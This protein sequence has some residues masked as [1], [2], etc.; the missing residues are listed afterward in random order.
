MRKNDANEKTYFRVKDR[1]FQI[2]DGWWFATREGDRGPFS[3]KSKAA[4]ELAEYVHE[5]RG[6]IDL[7]EV[8]VFDKDPD[9]R[10]V[11][12]GRSD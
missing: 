9:K 7:N 2:N 6:N 4:D 12:D 8:S 5:V 10:S 3:S 11:W 1:V